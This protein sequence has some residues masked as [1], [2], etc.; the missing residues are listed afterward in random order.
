MIQGTANQM[1]FVRRHSYKADGLE[2]IIPNLWP[3]HNISRPYGTL[4]FAGYTRGVYEIA[5]HLSDRGQ[6]VQVDFREIQE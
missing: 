3:G 4:G 5:A 6:A 2:H 1:N